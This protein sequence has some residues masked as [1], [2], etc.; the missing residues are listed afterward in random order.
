MYP[1]KL[2]DEK[3][4]TKPWYIG[5]QCS[6]KISRTTDY[7]I[8]CKKYYNMIQIEPMIIIDELKAQIMIMMNRAE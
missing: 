2:H 5:G 8:W 1:S 6:K 7:C 3:L 4:I